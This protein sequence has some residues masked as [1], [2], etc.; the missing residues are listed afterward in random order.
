MKR[1]I[2]KMLVML[3]ILAILFSSVSF[4]FADDTEPAANEDLP[5][6][7]VIDDANGD[8]EN[9]AEPSES[10]DPEPAH[11]HSAGE[12]VVEKASFGKDG[13]RKQLCSECG[14]VLAEEPV[15]MISDVSFDNEAAVYI[16]YNNETV[17]PA[18]IVKDSQGSVL[19]QDADYTIQF[20]DNDR[21]GTA[22]ATIMLQGD[23]YSGTKEFP[24]TILKGELNRT[25]LRVGASKAVV[26]D[27]AV[28]DAL[29]GNISFSIADESIATVDP[30]GN[31]TGVSAGKTILTATVGG[32]TFN[33]DVN[34]IQKQTATLLKA[35]LNDNG[36]YNWEC[37]HT[38]T[39]D[40]T[41][42][43]KAVVNAA[44]TDDL[45]QC[46][47]EVI[48]WDSEAEQDLDEYN[49]TVKEVVLKD[50]SG[51]VTFDRSCFTEGKDYEI[52][53]WCVYS[54]E[55]FTDCTYV[56]AEIYSI[57]APETIAF[58]ETYYEM[59]AGDKQKVAFTS[60]GGAASLITWSSSDKN[61]A[62]VSKG[63]V[64]AKGAGECTITAALLNGSIEQ[65]TVRVRRYD[66]LAFVKTSRTIYGTTPVK[67]TL[68]KQSSIK[69]KLIWKSSNTLIA[70]VDANGKLTPKKAGIV[71]VTVTNTVS[72]KK[73]SCKVTIIPKLKKKAVSLYIT[74]T[75]ANKLLSASAK[76]SWSSSNKKIATVSSAGKIT[77]QKPGTCTIT[78]KCKGK[79]YSCKVT[80]KPI[81]LSKTSVKLA[82]GKTV[83]LKVTGGSGSIKWKTS[84]KKVATVS[85]KG[86]VKSVEPG[87]CYISIT[88][89]GYTKKCKI[90]VYRL[91][92]D[93]GA[94]VYDYDTGTN[95][96]IVKFRNNGSRP[97]YITS[98]IDIKQFNYRTFDRYISLS[99]TVSI[100]PGKSKLVYFNVKG[101][102]TY[103]NCETFNLYYRFKYDGKTYKGVAWNDGSEYKKGTKWPATY[104]D[105][106]WYDEWDVY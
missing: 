103:R 27:K 80:V 22:T 21:A 63:T 56:D 32:Y 47:A 90:K 91:R 57:P 26:I 105:P 66:G 13:S 72:G 40:G 100:A 23:N 55:D 77:G 102:V 12:W 14:K 59:N 43:Y 46:K 70:A 88:R 75:Y 25:N 81:K 20:A 101:N 1:S 69:D 38:F 87:T 10:S 50:G 79:K 99:K 97:L 37:S 53:V 36:S 64:T 9:P 34:V 15:Y 4:T 48:L 83:K 84:N 94:Y 49:D 28:T 96:F 8:S 61:V 82:R 106:D 19:T 62:T 24:F 41:V 11:T 65:C 45:D 29:G 7:A 39:Y 3:T 60:D 54:G 78:A 85:S 76:V 67:L 51:T 58:D 71:T 18:L 92:P 31:I 73:A 5:T 74:K 89:N 52:S 33:G 6:D 17:T 98:G 16:S 93:F 86:L 42:T 68:T 35:S 2:Q 30:A 44:W 95:R 104:K